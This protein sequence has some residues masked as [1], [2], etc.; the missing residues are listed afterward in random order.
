M[1]DNKV[2]SLQKAKKYLKTKKNKIRD[3]MYVLKK[4]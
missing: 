3:Q 1:N 2:K 4:C